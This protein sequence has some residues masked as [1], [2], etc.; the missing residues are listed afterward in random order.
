MGSMG[1]DGGAARWQARVDRHHGVGSWPRALEQARALQLWHQRRHPEADGQAAPTARVQ[2]RT[3]LA[4]VVWRAAREAGRTVDDTTV[5]DVIAV[6]QRMADGGLGNGPLPSLGPHDGAL[7]PSGRTAE[8]ARG[9]LGVL[10]PHDGGPAAYG[11]LPARARIGSALRGVRADP[12][13]RSEQ[14]TW[15]DTLRAAQ[16]VSNAARDDLHAGKWR[17]SVHDHEAARATGLAGGPPP[18]YGYPAR[19]GPAEPGHPSW[20]QRAGWLLGLA[21]VLRDAAKMIPRTERGTVAPLDLVLTCYAG[22]A[23]E[24]QSAVDEL[25]P[26]WTAQAAED[27]AA[28]ELKHVPNGLVQQLQDTETAI[29]GLATTLWSI[30]TIPP[31]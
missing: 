14:G 21:P 24:L 13:A 8:V 3:L 23:E 12:E 19:P 16:H 18:A 9:L 25:D 10:R 22:L 4:V 6:C 30:T 27:S 11:I 29:H 26:L 17:I 7:P 28:W 15:R 2:E 5:A 20:L 1:S 31:T